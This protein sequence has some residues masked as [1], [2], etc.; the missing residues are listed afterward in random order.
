M[1][2]K[3]PSMLSWTRLLGSVLETLE[4]ASRQAAG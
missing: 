4:N 3:L 1:F 2:P